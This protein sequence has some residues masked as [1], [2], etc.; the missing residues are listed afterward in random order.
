[1]Y[2]QKALMALKK[3]K[4]LM[5]QAKKYNVQQNMLQQAVFNKEAA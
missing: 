3:K 2:K 1:M 5:D 4:Q